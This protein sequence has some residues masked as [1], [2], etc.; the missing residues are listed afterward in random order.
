MFQKRDLRSA[1]ELMKKENGVNIGML[2]PPDSGL[3]LDT[4]DPDQIKLAIT[5]AAED[6]YRNFG[7]KHEVELLKEAA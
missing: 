2:W 6:V 7:E 3:E 4:Q 5:E 1:F